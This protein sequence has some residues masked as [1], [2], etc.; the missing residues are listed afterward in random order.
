MP[1]NPLSSLGK[2][3]FYC[4]N[5]NGNANL[6]FAGNLQLVCGGKTALHANSP[7][8]AIGPEDWS[9]IHCEVEVIKKRPCTS[10]HK[11]CT[12]ASF[13]NTVIYGALEEV[14]LQQAF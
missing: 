12:P 10:Y 6:P 1:S 11:V 2:I 8:E 4:L 3:T 5:I 7:S 14:I 13:H 9:T